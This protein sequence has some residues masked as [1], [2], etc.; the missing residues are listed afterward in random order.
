MNLLFSLTYLTASIIGS[1]HR[2]LLLPNQ[3]YAKYK[4]SMDSFLL[5]VSVIVM[6]FSFLYPLFPRNSQCMILVH[7]RTVPLTG[8]CFSHPGRS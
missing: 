5:V 1:N 8:N 7:E 2:A 6:V 3:D 4:Y